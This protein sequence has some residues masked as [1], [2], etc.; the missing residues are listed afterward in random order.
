MVNEM[1]RGAVATLFAK[2]SLYA[3]DA[4]VILQKKND[5]KHKNKVENRACRPTGL[6]LEFTELRR[7]TI[8]QEWIPRWRCRG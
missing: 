3:C 7:P 6:C 2:M 1:Q 5:A 8:Q 4:A